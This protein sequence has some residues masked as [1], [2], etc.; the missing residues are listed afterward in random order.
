MENFVNEISVSDISTLVGAFIGTLIAGAITLRA[1][2]KQISHFKKNQLE[3]EDANRR[4]TLL[5]IKSFLDRPIRLVKGIKDNGFIID[6]SLGEWS[7]IKMIEQDLNSARNFITTNVYYIDP[8]TLNEIYELIKTIDIATE[9]AF[10]FNTSTSPKDLE[11]FYKENNINLIDDKI[12]NHI[13][14]LNF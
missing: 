12:I 14:K 4:R 2:N 11:K 5:V 8:D 3:T 13:L 6:Q 9:Y 7:Y 1:T 10:L